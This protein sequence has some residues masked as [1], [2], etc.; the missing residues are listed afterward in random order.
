MWIQ[1]LELVSTLCLLVRKVLTTYVLVE[2]Y[3]NY[4]LIRHSYPFSILAIYISHICK[5]NM[6]AYNTETDCIS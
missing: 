2:K 5:T 4:L 1:T 6:I 3:E